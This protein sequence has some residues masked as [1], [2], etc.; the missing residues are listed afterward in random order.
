MATRI[1]SFLKIDFDLNF[2]QLRN[3]LRKFQSNDRKFKIFFMANPKYLKK[4][5]PRKIIV[6]HRDTLET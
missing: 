6:T 3:S 2:V 1:F 4:K 5:K